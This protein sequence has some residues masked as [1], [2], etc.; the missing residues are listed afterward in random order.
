[1][2]KSDLNPGIIVMFCGFAGIIL[3][4]IE[5]ALYDNGTIIDEFIT[6]TITI[7]DLMALTIIIWIIIGI[8]IGVAKS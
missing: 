5:K 2:T 8:I 6:G 3:A 7:T 4:F 1:V